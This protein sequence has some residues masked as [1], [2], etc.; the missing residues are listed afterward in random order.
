MSINQSFRRDKDLRKKEIDSAPEDGDTKTEGGIKYVRK[1]GKWK[2]V[3]SKTAVYK[4]KKAK[5]SPG[6][7]VER[8]NT[9]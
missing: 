9:A 1:A 8:K 4:V 7:I 2:K 5:R 6:A 3:P